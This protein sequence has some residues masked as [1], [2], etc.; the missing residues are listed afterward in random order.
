MRLWLFG[1]TATLSQS[2]SSSGEWALQARS[3]LRKDT[4]FGQDDNTVCG[5]IWELQLPNEILSSSGT[6]TRLVADT[7]GIGTQ[8]GWDTAFKV[9]LRKWVRPESSVSASSTLWLPMNS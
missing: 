5:R 6:S 4:R 2:D 7:V 3:R 9:M 8:G 1:G